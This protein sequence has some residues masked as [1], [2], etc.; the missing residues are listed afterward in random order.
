MSPPENLTVALTDPGSKGVKPVAF[1]PDG[2]TL[3]A[4]DF[5][6]RAYLWN[7]C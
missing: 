2:K 1:S 3:A 6:G 7:V 5:N 4:G